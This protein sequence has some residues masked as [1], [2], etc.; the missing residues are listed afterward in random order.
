MIKEL[1]IA[2]ATRGYEPN[3]LT[4]YR[5]SWME[6]S[7]DF[8]LP[9]W[10]A[11]LLP[12]YLYGYEKNE[13][14]SV[15]NIEHDFNEAYNLDVNVGIVSREA[16]FIVKADGRTIYDRM[17]KSGAGEGEWTT[18][19]YRSEWNI[20]QNIFNKD[21]RIEIPAGSK[22]ITL[23]MTDGDWMTIND[24]KFFSVSGNGKVFN[25]T[26][27]NS[28][29]GEIFPPVRVNANGDVV[30][31][32]AFMQNKEWLRGRNFKPWEELIRNGG[33]AMVGEWGSYNKTPH[34]VVLSW[35]EDNL[36]IFKEADMGWA[37]WEFKGDFGILN[38]GRT[39]VDYE[40][41]NGHKLDRKMLNLL[42]KF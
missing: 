40:D 22:H 4:H 33:G 19:V 10:P 23:E 14:R 17:F 5:A 21:Y 26:P 20:Y 13:I 25:I 16:R 38:S 37:L 2:Q 27:N 8:P 30:S 1:G 41:F 11:A 35:M 32:N 3:T 31:D 6:G 34:D 9:V 39:D 24:L 15:L 29:W 18:A 7:N 36:Q 42:L 28:E 12:K